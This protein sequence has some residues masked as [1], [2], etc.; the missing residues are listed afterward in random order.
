[1]L[2]VAPRVQGKILETEAGSRFMV[3]ELKGRDIWR[4]RARTLAEAIE[5]GD[6]GIGVDKTLL[7]RAM[8]EQDVTTIMVV[9]EELRRIYLT[10][11]TDFFDEALSKG[12]ADWRGRATR[13][14]PYSRF[15][16]RY[17][18][19]SLQ[20]RKRTAKQTA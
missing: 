5:A 14:V 13:L 20:K 7:T 4:G 17:V 1:M 19:P 12:R 3:V 11:I 8:R 6:C 10:P 16:Q 18:G 9:V 2:K 15:V